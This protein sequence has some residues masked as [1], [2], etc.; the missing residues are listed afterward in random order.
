MFY[1][2][3]LF[4]LPIFYYG[5]Y[6]QFTGTNFYD[7]WYV[8]TFNIIN[9]LPI[10]WFGVFD[11]QYPKETFLADSNLYKLGLKNWCFNTFIFW[12]WYFYAIWQGF[13]LLWLT[14]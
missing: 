2:N 7:K 13:A 1:K 11:W 3:V 10:C 4:C 14:Y 9:G 5:I 6:S 8:Q 12:R